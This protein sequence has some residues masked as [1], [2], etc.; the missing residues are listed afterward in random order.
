MSTLATLALKRA[1]S[2]KLHPSVPVPGVGDV[3]L[4]FDAKRF[5][6]GD[7]TYCRVGPCIEDRTVTGSSVLAQ[8]D[9]FTRDADGAE[10]YRTGAVITEILT[11]GGL[12]DHSG[13][14]FPFL[15]AGQS[16]DLT[17]EGPDGEDVLHLILQFDVRCQDL[18]RAPGR[19]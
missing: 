5:D 11:E 1:L 12:A 14:A 13:F 15:R 9:V 2:A 4:R 8:I 6:R 16:L 7:D 19:F 17:E 3:P 18:N 10:A